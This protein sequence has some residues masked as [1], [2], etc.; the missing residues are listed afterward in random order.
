MAV[1]SHE[2]RFHHKGE[3]ILFSFSGLIVA[4]KPGSRKAAR[5]A[6]LIS[7]LRCVV[8]WHS[9]V[10]VLCYTLKLHNLCLIMFCGLVTLLLKSTRRKI[11]P[12]T[13]AVG[14]TF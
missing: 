10:V 7:R 1:A 14:R 2:E 4:R 9:F 6:S 12:N 5:G 8:F 13:R 3:K 11:L